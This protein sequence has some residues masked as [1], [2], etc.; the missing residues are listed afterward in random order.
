MPLGKRVDFTM[1]GCAPCEYPICFCGD[2]KDWAHRISTGMGSVDVLYTGDLAYVSRTNDVQL[3]D[4]AV[5]A[6]MAA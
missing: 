2:G 6:R 4:I 3:Q 5:I 1:M